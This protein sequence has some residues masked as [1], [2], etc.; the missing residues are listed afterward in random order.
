VILPSPCEATGWPNNQALKDTNIYRYQGPGFAGRTAPPRFGQPK[1]LILSS[2][3]DHSPS[4]SPEGERIAFVSTRTGDD[5]IWV[6]DRNGG[7]TCN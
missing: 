4:I 5:E 1:S 2:R 3:K 7:R 6:C